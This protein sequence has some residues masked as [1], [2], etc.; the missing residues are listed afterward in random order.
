MILTPLQQKPIHDT[1]KIFLLTVFLSLIFYPNTVSAQ[2]TLEKTNW[3]VAKVKE[4]I[5]IEYRWLTL[6]D[7][8]KTRE[9]KVS[10]ET[11]ASIVELIY[12]LSDVTELRNWKIGSKETDVLA[13]DHEKW[14][15]YSVYNIPFPFNQQDL[16]TSY[17]IEEKSNTFTRIEGNASPKY[18]AEKKGII[19]QQKYHE[20]W[21][22]KEESLAKTSVVF[23]SIAPTDPLLPRFIQ[24]RFIQPILISSFSKLRERAELKYKEDKV[25]ESIYAEL[26]D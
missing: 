22:L 2:K 15:L 13:S 12:C 6:E 26:I 11:Q 17:T 8:F 19:R 3:E 5:Q 1:L 18:L 7:G 4:G 16:I 10:L 20:V 14:I 9:L 21:Q 24:D 23:T 25:L